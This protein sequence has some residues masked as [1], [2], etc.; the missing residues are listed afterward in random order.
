MVRKRR[1]KASEFYRKRPPMFVQQA[2]FEEVFPDIDRVTVE[3]EE[4]GY[5]AGGYEKSNLPGE[6]IDCSNPQCYG[7]GFSIGRILRD[8][9][10]QKQTSLST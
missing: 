2:A 8:M 9:T 7:G 1:E 3:V 5:G 10:R 6:F 4:S